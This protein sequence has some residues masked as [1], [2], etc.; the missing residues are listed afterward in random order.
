VYQTNVRLPFDSYCC[1]DSCGNNE[2]HDLFSDNDQKK[3][4]DVVSPPAVSDLF[5]KNA[6]KDRKPRDVVSIKK[7][8]PLDRLER[9]DECKWEN[10]P[11]ND[12]KKPYL[13]Y[14]K[15]YRVGPISK[16]NLK[17]G[18]EGSIDISYSETISQSFSEEAGIG[19]T[20]FEAIGLSMSFSYSEEEAKENGYTYSHKYSVPNGASGY[21]AWE[22]IAECKTTAM[23]K[24]SYVFMC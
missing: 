16:C 4:R 14:E 15:Q 19:A 20:L 7:R 18:C 12:P 11:D 8:A 21:V 23:T 24:V 1:G 3:R 6:S 10:H 5:D 9:R 22:P 17:D 2:V 13:V